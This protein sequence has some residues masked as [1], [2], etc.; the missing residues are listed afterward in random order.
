MVGMGAITLWLAN[1]R[2]RRNNDDRRTNWIPE[3]KVDQSFRVA[4]KWRKQSSTD[5]HWE[6]KVLSF[7]CYFK[8]SILVL[9]MVDFSSFLCNSF[10]WLWLEGGEM[11]RQ[12][13]SRRS[14][15]CRSA[16]LK[17]SIWCRLA[18]TWLK[19]SSLIINDQ[20]PLEVTNYFKWRITCLCHHLCK[21]SS[22][23][24][25]WRLST[26]WRRAASLLTGS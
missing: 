3:E 23:S 12:R 10:C 25:L 15:K 20:S 13:Q 14:I 11:R 19:E 18:T 6:M 9:S 24:I 16:T 5:H 26:A 2:Q 8:S 4:T 17:E 7:S 22:R 21:S 1:L